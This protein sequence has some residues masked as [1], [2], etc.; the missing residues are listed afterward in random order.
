MLLKRSVSPDG[1][2]DSFSVEFSMPVSDIPDGEIKTKAQNV[3]Q[4]QIEIVGA[5]LGHDKH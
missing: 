1:R 5:F 2:I 4:L 3:L